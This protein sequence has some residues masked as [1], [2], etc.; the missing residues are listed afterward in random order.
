MKIPYRTCT[1]SIYDSSRLV[2]VLKL[3]S[4]KYDVIGFTDEELDEYMKKHILAKGEWYCKDKDKIFGGG[5]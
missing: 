3:D 2:S 5:S 1:V 4:R